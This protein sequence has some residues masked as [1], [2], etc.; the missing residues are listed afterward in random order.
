MEYTKDQ[1]RA[2][3]VIMSGK[4]VFLTGGAGTG[5]STVL[6]HII[7]AKRNEG[8]QVVVC[9]PTG[10]AAANIQGVTIHRAFGLPI[11]PAITKKSKIIKRVPAAIKAADLIVIDEISMVRT[12]LMDAICLSVE[13]ARR[14]ANKPIQ[15]VVSGDFCQLPPIVSP[16]TGEETVLRQHYKCQPAYWWAFIAPFWSAQGFTPINLTEIVRQSDQQFVAALNQV[17]LNES[18][19][20]GVNYINSH[21]KYQEDPRAVT[22]MATNAEVDRINSERLKAL[23]GNI[24]IFPT[25][26]TGTVLPSEFGLNDVLELKEGAR[27]II[28]ANADFRSSFA[29]S[30]S[31]SGFSKETIYNGLGATVVSLMRS[32]DPSDDYV[33]VNT[34]LHQTFILYRKKYTAY[35]YD[36][37]AQ[38]HVCQS[39]V[40]EAAQFP[41]RLGYAH[42]IHKSQ[43]LSFDSM[44]LDPTT[45]AAG[46]LYVA[47]SRVRNITGLHLLRPLNESD[48]KIDPVVASFYRQLESSPLELSVADECN[49]QPDAF[50]VRFEASRTQAKGKQKDSKS[51]P[52]KTGRPVRYPHGSKVVR[53]PLELAPSLERVLS[54]ICP[55]T[56]LQSERLSDLIDLLDSRFE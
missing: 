8:K 48:A 24:V 36:V 1:Q 35:T 43:G 17:R 21:A 15:F 38:G 27:V 34:D 51:T 7:K 23:S 32:D 45:F 47:L 33:V 19:K 40:G 26:T 14:K 52:V 44:N 22:L 11:G 42:T 50:V 4:D 54:L 13:T 12:D 53:V 49:T 31:Y 3:N 25:I 55:K 28:T 10:G 6:R 18:L 5:K 9:A 46:Q 30:V 39:V 37:D 56:G 20:T 29:E 2:I 16:L 41:L